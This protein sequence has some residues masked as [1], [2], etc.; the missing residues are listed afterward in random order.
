MRIAATKRDIEGEIIL[1]SFEFIYAAGAKKEQD[2]STPSKL[3]GKHL[4]LL[5]FIW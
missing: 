2:I 5:G 4:Q 3:E 1:T